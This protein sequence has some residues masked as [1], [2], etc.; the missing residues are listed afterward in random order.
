MASL[1]RIKR[2][3]SQ[4]GAPGSLAQGELAYTYKSDTLKLY[5]GTGT[6]T[7]GAAANIEVIGGKYFTDMMDH[8]LGTLTASSAILVDANSKIDVLNVDNLTL[9][10]NTLSSTDTNGDINIDPDGTGAVNLYNPY[11]YQTSTSSLVS[12]DE[13]IQDAASV[14]VDGGTGITDSY[15]DST[16]VVTLDLDNTAVTPGSYGSTTQIP[17]FT[18]D[19]QGRLTAAGSVSVATT[20]NLAGESG[21]GS[22]DLLSQTL[23][24]T[25]GEGIDVV[26]GNQTIT[27]SGED[28]SD[29][30]KGVASFDATD[31]TVTNGNVAVNTITLGSSSLNP[32][33][34]TTDIAGLTSV[35]VDN[36][37]VDGNTVSTSTG[38]LTLNPTGN[39]DVNSNRIINLAEPVN[40]QDAATKYYVDA[41]R[42]GLDIKN[43]VRA[44]TTAAVTLASD[45]ENGDTLDGV[46]LATGDRVLVKNQTDA[47]ENGIYVV[48][49]SGAPS[50]STDADQ[51][52]ELNAGTFVFIEEGTVNDNTGF[53]VVSDNPLTIGTDDIEWTL[54]SS[55][56]TLIAGDGLS[57]NGY[58]L[59]VNTANGLQIAS[60][61]VEL[62]PTVAGAGLTFTSGVVDIVGTANRITVN[63]NDIDIAST[64]V[65]Q[66][67]ITTLGTVTTGTW[68][69][70][71]V[72]DA[73]VANDLTISGGTV[74]NTPIGATTA[75]SGAFTTLTA[76][77]AVTF[78]ANTASTSTTTGTLVVTGG[79]GMSGTMYVGTN[80]VG[81][82]AGTSDIDG[83][84]IDGGTY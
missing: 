6:E 52:A 37:N 11:I 17:T 27:V 24:I 20:L 70:D 21:T 14:A 54:F 59:E 26:A 53:V 51:P 8:T 56:G 4:T 65:G 33:Q 49:A 79:I 82:G 3:G 61:N 41:A 69:A 60:D 58:T 7:N 77:D 63:A 55:S 67:S 25:G 32:G 46:T 23:T 84:N 48:A 43:S 39:V 13:Y 35:T 42:S 83:F 28:A 68:N 15:N 76:N 9:D 22:V 36:I 45:L 18:V 5:I 38:D 50:R 71:I 75:S 10:G 62:A 73:Y 57:K 16:G 64:Y 40:D 74:D 12:L 81:A 30:N 72:Q 66:T 1:I 2:S 78:T 34:T 47:S 80:L 31:F 19:Q 29:V 44:A